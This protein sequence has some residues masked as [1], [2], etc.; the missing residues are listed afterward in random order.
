M[1]RHSLQLVLAEQAIADLEDIL[2]YTLE[3]WG[4]AQ[5]TAYASILDKALSRICENPHIGKKR[6]ELSNKHR[7]IPAG[8]HTIFYAATD[9][10]VYVSRIM[11]GKM[12]IQNIL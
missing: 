12:D 8:Q 6:P 10:A 7:S 4:E 3:T 5:V 11:H 1:S 2:Q 9:H